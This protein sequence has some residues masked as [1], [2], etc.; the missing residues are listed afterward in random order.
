MSFMT[1]ISVAGLVLGVAVLVIVLSVMNG[2]ER[3]LRLRVLGVLPQGIIFAEDEFADWRRTVD[4]IEL[5]PEVLAAAPFV[6]GGGLLVARGKIAGISFFGVDPE[7]EQKV[8]IVGD[9]FLSG[10]MSLLE[11]GKF[12]LAMGTSLA[13]SL[14][15]DVG[16][17]VTLVLPDA[18]LTLAGPIPRSKR[19]EVI[20]LF[21]VGSDADKNQIL[22]SLQDTL[23]LKRQDQV[24]AIR[25]TTE[26]LFQAPRILSEILVNLARDD[27]Y[28]VSW[29]RRHRNLY[30]AIQ[31]QK[32][33]L[34]ILL[35]MVVAVA[36]FNVVSNLVMIV[37]EKKPD[38]AIL[39]TMGASTRE[40]LAIFV[41]HGLLIGAIGILLGLGLGIMISSYITELY[42]VIDNVFKLGLMD[43]YF[44]HYLPTEILVGDLALIGLVT[45][46]ICLVVTIYPARMAART[47]PVEALKYE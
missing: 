44:I 35:L 9:Y 45:L 47:D 23:K 29:M 4:R 31:M 6:E 17:K 19:F 26:D 43:E 14:S 7:M 32:S 28:A 33:T 3:E 2:F 11:P 18:Q 10:D 42:L 34:F 37:N 25:I 20:G 12:R 46:L 41:I 30:D 13:K 38:I 1:F 15:V 5:H 36:A 16:D 40:I 22:I 27:L 8:S 21:E 39:R 24:R